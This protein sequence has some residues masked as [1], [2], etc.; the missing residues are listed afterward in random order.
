MSQQTTLDAPARLRKPEFIT[1][2][3]L[4]ESTDLERVQQ[5][6]SRYPVEW[7]VLFSPKRQGTEPRYPNVAVVQQIVARLGNLQ[8][9]AHL[10]GGYAR[11]ALTQ[12]EVSESLLQRVAGFARIQ[13]NYVPN[14]RFWPE[15]HHSSDRVLGHYE[16]GRFQ[17]AVDRPVILQHRLVSRWPEEKNLHFLFDKSGGRGETP[18]S[19]PKHP[20]GE[21]LVGY[22]GGISPE[23]VAAGVEKIDSSG[24]YWLDMEGRVRDNSDWM[25]LDRVQAVCQQVYG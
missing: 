14:P 6:S 18:S 7:G 2:T 8:L 25:D 24:P 3:G 15:L 21:R 17:V 1:F 20:D 22:A 4:D 13:L 23:N 19:W 5:I 9:A 11:Q 10:C 16:A 12:P